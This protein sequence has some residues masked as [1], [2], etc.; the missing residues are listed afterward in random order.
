MVFTGDSGLQQTRSSLCW[1][2]VGGPTPE[3][4]HIITVP[5]RAP[6]EQPRGQG[7]CVSLSQ[8][9]IWFGV[10]RF[11]VCLWSGDA[12]IRTTHT[13]TVFQ[14][15]QNNDPTDSTY[16]DQNVPVPE[17]HA[18]VNCGCSHCSLLK[19][20]WNFFIY[21]GWNMYH[22]WFVIHWSDWCHMLSQKSVRLNQSYVLM[23]I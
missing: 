7:M 11:R 6:P 13:Q 22:R 3:N 8:R 1:L 12:V 2:V 21:K 14:P 23:L 17:D 4:G 20:I 19:W 9:E 16:F 5:S 10:W 18:E 15:N